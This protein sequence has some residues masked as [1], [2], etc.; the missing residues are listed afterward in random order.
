MAFPAVMDCQPRSWSPRYIDFCT[1]RQWR[2]YGIKAV[3]RKLPDLMM[4]IHG[5]HV[6]AHIIRNKKRVRG[7]PNVAFKTEP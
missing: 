6:G 2:P 7:Y 4:A 3:E 1:D 5:V